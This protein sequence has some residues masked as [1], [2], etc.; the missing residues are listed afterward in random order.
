MARYRTGRLGEEIKKSISTFL[1]SEA[2]DRRLTSRLISISGVDV[3]RDGSYATCYVSP[4]LLDGEDKTA[5]YK[6]VLD[7]LNHAKG[8]LRTK[9]AHDVN[10]RHTPELIF[11]IDESA[12]YGRRIESIIR[13]L[14][15]DK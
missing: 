9:V 5:I 3:T 8:V 4:L 6:E 13:E 15:N 14:E 10:I 2:G 12:E 1:V 11:K 7:A